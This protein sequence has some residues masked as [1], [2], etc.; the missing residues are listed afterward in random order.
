MSWFAEAAVGLGV[1]L[2]GE[3]RAQF[4]AFLDLL[5]AWNEQMNLT[6]VRD[7]L[8]IEKR[9]F[10]DSLTCVL[11][12]GNLNGRRLIDIGT[13]AGFPGLPLKI[14]FPELTLTLV[15]SITK[16]SQFLQSVVQ[17]CGLTDV[18]ILVERAEEL[19]QQ[20]AHREQYDWAVGRGVAEMRVL[21]EYLLPLCRVGGAMLAQK[22]ENAAAET[23]VANTAIHLL[24]GGEPHL[25]P[26]QIPDKIEPHYLVH[27]EKIMP[28]SEK[29]PRRVGVPA[30]RPL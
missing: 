7:P 21:A 30:K 9:H 3:Q 24:G 16:K 26:V 12:T 8:T 14:A 17:T 27:I 4:Q 2:S 13:G 19:G 18:S 5:L 1:S 11:V 15:E 6:A 25:H 20:P 29:Y 22:G 28:T 23:A 10:Y